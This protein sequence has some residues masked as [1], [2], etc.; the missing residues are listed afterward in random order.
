MKKSGLNNISNFI[1]TVLM[2]NF[3]YKALSLAI[4]VVAWLIIINVADPVTSKTFKGLPVEAINKSAISSINRV[5]EVVEGDTVDFTVRGKASII[6]NLSLND[7]SATADLSKLSPVYA[8]D[9]NVVCNKVDN[10]EID[11]GNKM[12]VVKL[13]DIATRTMQVTVDTVGDVADGYYVGDYEVKPNM[14]MISGGKSKIEQIDSVKVSVDVSGAKKNFENRIVPVAYD[15]DGNEL[16]SSYYTFYNGDN[17]I[18]DIQVGVTIYN[19]KTLPVIVKVSGTPAQ[20]YVYSDDYEFTPEVITV[21]GSNKRLSKIDKFEVPIDITGA[22]ENYEVNVNISEYLPDGIKL[23]SEEENIS[24]RV[25]LEKVVSNSILISLDDIEMRNL[26]EGYQATFVGDNTG[27]V[28]GLSGTG[29]Q[30]GSYTSENVGAYIDLSNAGEGLC[31]VPVRYE[32]VKDNLIT[33]ENTVVAV[34]IVNT[35][36]STGGTDVSSPAP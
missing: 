26:K 17:L 12:L 35:E 32:N 6:K 15:K 36:N 3:I 10:I 4:A 29:A 27:I 28:L 2:N 22:G 21:G 33:S 25:S 20:G 31:N 34:N 7:F 24:V 11:S 13:E 8:T 30:V 1:K 5:Y 9:I 16:D 18:T 14:I 23:V 19:T